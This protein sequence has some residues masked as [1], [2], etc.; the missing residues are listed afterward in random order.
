M[1]NCWPDQ[2]LTKVTKLLTRY[3]ARS[4]Q[5][6]GYG[7]FFYPVICFAL[8][9]TWPLCFSFCNAIHLITC[10]FERHVAFMFLSHKRHKKFWHT[11]FYPVIF[12]LRAWSLCFLRVKDSIFTTTSILLRPYA[13]VV[14]PS[15]RMYLLLSKQERLHFVISQL[16]IIW[17]CALIDFIECVFVLELNRVPRQSS[18]VVSRPMEQ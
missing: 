2:M 18:I 4:M 7:T 1:Q 5:S 10:C 8:D 12:L 15:S 17:L 11:N 14:I 13:R 3:H 6:T 9:V 16:V